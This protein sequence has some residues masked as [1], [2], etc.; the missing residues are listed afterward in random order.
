MQSELRGRERKNN[1][2]RKDGCNLHTHPST[3]AWH[4][5]FVA[6][7]V[8]LVIPERKQTERKKQRRL[9]RV[10]P[11]SGTSGDFV[12]QMDRGRCK[13]RPT[14]FLKDSTY[15]EKYSVSAELVCRWESGGSWEVCGVFFGE[16]CDVKRWK[17][18]SS[19]GCPAPMNQA[20]APWSSGPHRSQMGPWLDTGRDEG[21]HTQAGTNR[22]LCTLQIQTW[23]CRRRQICA[24][25]QHFV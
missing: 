9:C 20:E 10:S 19:W 21:T 15:W 2:Q 14:F 5:G 8:K 7:D 12:M 18:D 3:K 22:L 13:W 25:S 1:T 24:G 16:V 6:F 11:R 23:E 4:G 17:W